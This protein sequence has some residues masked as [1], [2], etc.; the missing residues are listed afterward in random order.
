MAYLNAWALS[1]DVTFQRKLSAALA[2]IANDVQSESAGTP[3]HG[4]RQL[5]AQ[6]VAVDSFGWAVRVAPNVIQAVPALKTAAD[7]GGTAGPWTV[8]DADLETGISTVWNTFAN[9]LT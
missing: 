9:V 2:K 5:L 4:L 6:K 3:S 8:T 1:N 7:T